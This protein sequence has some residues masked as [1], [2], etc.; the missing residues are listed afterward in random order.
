MCSTDM[1]NFNLFVI[2]YI[3]DDYQL[4]GLSPYG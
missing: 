3:C 4:L 2:H 1:E